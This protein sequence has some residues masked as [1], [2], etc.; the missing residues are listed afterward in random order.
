MTPEE[1]EKL[2]PQETLGAADEEAVRRLLAASAGPLETPP[3]VVHRL[4]QVL[5]DLKAEPAGS[6]RDT[7][8]AARTTVGTAA[9]TNLAGRRTR[10]WPKV[11]VAA[12]AVSLLGVGLG[13]VMDDLGGSA[14]DSATAGS[15]EGG[16]VA[17]EQLDAGAAVEDDDRDRAEASPE[18]V[19]P[20]GGAAARSLP[21][22]RTESV[23]V[24]AARILAFTP[25]VS[26]DGDGPQL[27]S[28]RSVVGSCLS[29]DLRRG[30]LAVA[31]RLD[32]ERATLVFRAARDGRRE[33]EVYPCDDA[34]SPVVT[35]TVDPR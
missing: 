31:V 24:D 10:R 29:P 6:R 20:S 34:T 27:L 25:A 1:P 5:A 26:A 28:E 19:V 15:A 2:G 8:P 4:D 30:D 17:R 32:G 7:D 9:V 13:N 23:T 14:S 22:L 33:V 16:A 12:A 21:R 18:Q 3:D 11:L 35:T